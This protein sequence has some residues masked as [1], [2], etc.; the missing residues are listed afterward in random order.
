MDDKEERVS[1]FKSLITWYRF[2]L[3][4]TMTIVYNVNKT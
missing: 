1:I 3:N 4:T 2:L